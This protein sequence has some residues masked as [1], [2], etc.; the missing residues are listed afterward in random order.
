MSKVEQPTPMLLPWGRGCQAGLPRLLA[1]VSV[2]VCA[3]LLGGCDQQRDAA[4]ESRVVPAD[5]KPRAAERV[6]GKLREAK[7]FEEARATIEGQFGAADRDIGSGLSI[8]QWD[9]D[10][11]VLTLHPLAGPTF[12]PDDGDV[13]WLVDT[14]NPLAENLLGSYEMAT[15]PDPDNRGTTYWIGNLDLAADGTYSFRDS[16]TN[17]DDKDGQEHNF[18]ANHPAGRY[19]IAYSP[20]VGPDTLLETLETETAVAE[21]TFVAKNGTAEQ[22]YSIVSDAHARRL[23]FSA[24]PEIEFAM[25]KSWSN[26]WH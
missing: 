12:S 6:A 24:A 18:F 10:E 9:L 26:F 8:E 11:G 4:D 2:F 13:L 23:F 1:V 22:Q 21:V 20:G 19:E 5:G 3:L 14:R 15:R 16:R 7:T 17:R 25:D